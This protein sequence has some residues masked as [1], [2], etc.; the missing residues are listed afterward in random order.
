[1]FYERSL[2]TDRYIFAQNCHET[3]LM[4]DLEWDI[5]TDWSN[6]LLDTQGDVHI[7]GIIYLRAE[8]TT[9]HERLQKRGRIE[10]NGITLDYLNQLHTKHEDWLHHRNITKHDSLYDVPILE[11]DCNQ[12][13]E[14][15]EEHRNKLLL[16][17]KEFIKECHEHQLKLRIEKMKRD[18]QK[19]SM[20]YKKQKLVFDAPDVPY[21]KPLIESNQE[22]TDP[23]TVISSPKK[24]ITKKLEK[25]D[26][27]PVF[28]E[29]INIEE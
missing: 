25:L 11:L 2:Y 21:K 10:E 16:K 12:E 18:Q 24:Q 20:A 27:N 8:P 9:S 19:Q 13:F 15:D 1:M 28:K 26:C 6:Y 7:H 3:N 17:V 14:N 4:S 29:G 22:N 5:Y 23:T